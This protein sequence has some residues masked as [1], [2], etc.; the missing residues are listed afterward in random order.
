ML[1]M[2]MIEPLTLHTADLTKIQSLAARWKPVHRAA[3]SY[4]NCNK[5]ACVA[6]TY[7]NSAQYKQIHKSFTDQEVTP[8]KHVLTWPTL[9]CQLE[10]EL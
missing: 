6:L 8:I 2:G 4:N 5:H 10:Y 3:I 7:A 1:L 9:N